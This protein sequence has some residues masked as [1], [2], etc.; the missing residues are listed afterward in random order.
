MPIPTSSSKTLNL[1]HRQDADDPKKSKR[2]C[3]PCLFV[4]RLL[5]LIFLPA[6]AW[7]KDGPHPP[8]PTITLTVD[9]KSV[10]AEVADEDHER[11]AGLMFRE[12]LPEGSGMLFVM[13][14]TAP[15]SFWMKNTLVPLSIAYISP[16]GVIL[17]IHDMTPHEEKPVQSRFPNVAYALEMRKGWFSDNG[18]FPGT[19]ITGLPKAN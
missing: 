7:A 14:S 3:H 12:S 4:G 15:A 11:S 8:L 18:I 19:R 5:L 9:S 10:R 6:L 16:A 2:W 13:P 17:E 1:K